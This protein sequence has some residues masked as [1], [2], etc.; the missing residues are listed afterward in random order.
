[1]KVYILAD[2]LKGMQ[3]TEKN[4]KKATIIF[5]LLLLGILVYLVLRPILFTVF[6]GLLLG[7]I[8]MPIYR[9]VV[10]V[11]HNRDIAAGIIVALI[12]IIVAV[13]FWLILPTVIDQIFQLF[14]VLQ[15]LDVERAVQ[16]FFPNASEQFTLQLSLIIKDF[17]SK[18]TNLILTSALNIS[19]DI[20][21]I[22]LHSF[23]MVFVLYFTLRDTE[24]LKD[25]VSKISPLNSTRQKAVA[26]HFKDITDSIL[27]GQVL[28][29]L[30]QGIF[31]GIGIFAV[32]IS[33]A[34][35]ITLFT[36]IVCIL[37]FLGAFIVWVP[38]MIY[39]F[40]SGQTT[41]G[42]L[43]LIYNLII[44]SNVDN[45][46]RSY[47]VARKTNVSQPII[48]IGMMGGLLVFGLAGLIIGPL[49]L[50]Y[51]MALLKSYKDKTLYTFFSDEDKG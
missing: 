42:F 34:L 37:P 1:M 44:V 12:V 41:A 26:K 40:A 32:G 14:R 51:F 17:F 29:G 22:L 46:V 35:T 28:G 19:L 39:L 13:P 23:L 3:L 10:H 48:F 47:V 18:I 15:T 36:M 38:I 4:V 43:F 24:E 33:G 11:I 45:L 49:V 30:I 50:V 2:F 16:G 25:F 5:F 8:L 27:Y 21:N 9:K 31:A 6:A 20:P 7:Y